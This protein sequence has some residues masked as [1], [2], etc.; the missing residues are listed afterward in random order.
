M[1]ARTTIAGILA[2]L[3]LAVAAHAGYPEGQA[4]TFSDF[5]RTR[6]I[7]VTVV[8][9]YFATAQGIIC[10]NQGED[11]WEEPLPAIPGVDPEDISRIWADQFG[12]TLYA[13]TPDGRYVYDQTLAMWFL[14]SETPEGDGAAREVPP[15]AIMHAPPGFNYFAGGQLID[16]YGRTWQINEMVDDGSGMYW[17]AI[18]GYGPAKAR[19]TNLIID[20]LPF[21]LVQRRVNALDQE[22]GRLWVSG[23]VYD[24]LR[25]GI[26]GFEPAM[27][28]FRH[29][30]SGVRPEFPADDINCLRS[31]SAHLYIGTARGLLVMDLESEMIMRTVGE[32]QGLAGENVLSIAVTGDSVF[33]GTDEGLNLVIGASDSA[34]LI[35]P[36]TFE[37]QYIWDIEE[38][39]DYVWVAAESGA[40]R[41]TKGAERLQRYRDPENVLFSHVYDIERWADKLWFVSDGGLAELDLQTAE[42]RSFHDMTQQL[43]PRALAVNE[44]IAAV[45]SDKGL[46]I[47]F[48]TADKPFKRDFTVDDGLAS[49]NVYALAV[50]GDYLWVGTDRGLTRFLWNNPDRVD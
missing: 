36:T 49:N 38:V 42:S 31:D 33:I 13:A 2:G 16:P 4:V 44:T 20:L 32:R 35:L 11:R 5:S 3:L 40:Y 34:A 21:G 26:T 18:W 15:P 41:L 46:T 29:L 45:A 27:M 7:A 48:H 28:T 47:L 17:M 12:R 6:S 10:Y 14:T 50:D 22:G 19:T 8:R 25:T 30:E 43:L 39:G 24:D 1:K 9:V 23:A 37:G